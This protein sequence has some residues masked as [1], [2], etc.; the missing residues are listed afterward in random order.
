[1]AMSSRNAKC[2]FWLTTPLKNSMLGFKL[3]STNCILP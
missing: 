2:R 3:Q 1:M